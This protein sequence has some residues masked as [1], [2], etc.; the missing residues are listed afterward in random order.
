LGTGSFTQLEACI[1][2]CLSHNKYH[3]DS[4]HRTT[5]YDHSHKSLTRASVLED[6]SYEGITSPKHHHHYSDDHH[7]YSNDHHHYSN[8]HHH[9]Y[10]DYHHHSDNHKRSAALLSLN[11]IRQ[12]NDALAKYGIPVFSGH[13][14]HYDMYNKPRPVGDIISACQL[15]LQDPTLASLRTGP[16]AVQHVWDALQH[17][18]PNQ[19]NHAVQHVWDALQHNQP[20]QQNH[21]VQ[22]VWDAVQHHSPPHGYASPA[23]RG[24]ASHLFNT[25]QPPYHPV[26][27]V[28]SNL[29]SGPQQ[30]HYTASP[31]SNTFHQYPGNNNYGR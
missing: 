27:N 8:D 3:T 19:Q 10:S 23:M 24:V 25:S 11:E 14:H 29:F 17:S 2:C 4:I 16:P 13:D 12:V 9:P 18:Q 6:Y 5:K 31:F 20:N 26:N 22:H 1:Q 30:Q 21:A 7:H 28:A 15:I